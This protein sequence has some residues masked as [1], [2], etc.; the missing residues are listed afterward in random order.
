MGRTT[1]VAAHLAPPARPP[2]A[3]TVFEDALYICDVH[4]DFAKQPEDARRKYL[5]M[6]GRP[7]CWRRTAE[8]GDTA[9]DPPLDPPW[10]IKVTAIEK[11]SFKDNAVYIAVYKGD[12]SDVRFPLHPSEH[13]RRPLAV[14]PSHRHSLTLYPARL[15]STHGSAAPT[16]VCMQSVTKQK[17]PTTYEEG[18]FTSKSKT[19]SR[20]TIIIGG[21]AC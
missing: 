20:T 17:P 19:N 9:V 13:P 10:T 8:F 1:E 4:S 18:S 21:A 11:V 3:H 14:T 12:D 5:D 16:T 7:D 2:V 6:Y 15:C